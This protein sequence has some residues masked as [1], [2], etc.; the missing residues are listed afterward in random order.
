MVKTLAAILSLSLSACVVNESRQTVTAPDGTVTVTESKSQT[1]D[2]AAF[3]AGANA[4]V[5]LA[6]PRAQVIREK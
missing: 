1:I 6:A 2:A 4:V 3:T 5:T